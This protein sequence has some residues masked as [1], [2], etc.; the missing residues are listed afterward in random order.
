M[1]RLITALLLLTL[2]ACEKSDPIPLPLQWMLTIH[3]PGS[4]SSCPSRGLP[5]GAKLADT[6]VDAPGATGSLFGVPGKAA[7]GVCGGGGQTGSTDV[8]T[9][10]SATPGGEAYIILA[11]SGGK[12]ANG[13][14]ADFVVFEN[15]FQKQ[16]G[17]YFLE[18]AIVEVGHDG[19]NWCGFNPLYASGTVYSGDPVDWSGFAG[20]SPVRFNQD[21]WSYGSAEIFDPAFAGGDPFDLSS[22]SPDNSFNIGCSVAL[23]D[24]LVLNG[25]TYL[26]LT[27]AA[28]R[29]NPATGQPYPIDPASYDG[30]SD[31]DGVIA[32]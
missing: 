23:R 13:A 21:T 18:P 1:R 3:P 17:S 27:S 12:V 2:I 31:I 9:L 29:I 30:A 14:G 8:Y 19:T 7:N 6:V 24:D 11:F 25:F 28:S 10:H 5:A 4:A 26:R 32:R 15:P 16:N 22:L 20:L